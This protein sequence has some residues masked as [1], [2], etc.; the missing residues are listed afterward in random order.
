MY[1]S[2]LRGAVLFVL[3]SSVALGACSSGGAAR[4]GGAG[5]G[6]NG[7]VGLG[8]NGGVGVDGNGGNGSAGSCDSLAADFAPT[9]V[10]PRGAWS[11]G[12]TATLG[13]TFTIFTNFSTSQ[14]D[15]LP[16]TPS[17]AYWNDP[18]VA[19][20]TVAI[21]PST[22]DI[23]G[24][25]NASVWPNGT[26]TVKPGQILMHPGKAGPYSVSRWT[27]AAA[28]SFA[29]QATF[30]GLSGYSGAPATTTDVHIQHNGSDL[31]S[32]NLNAS[33][34]GNSFSAAPTVIVGVGDTIDFAV[35][36]GNASNLYDSTGV[37]AVVCKTH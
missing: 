15:V 1:L 11:Y 22:E 7:V 18:L 34:F 13:S 20:L 35:G 25:I 23:H 3:A 10:N 29:V 2:T 17:L 14:T 9:G 4:G 19:D 28:G 32:G 31:V 12:W 5:A 26:T 36:Y 24:G 33:G 30:Q 21:N 27:A 8:G 16:G 6:G 37:D